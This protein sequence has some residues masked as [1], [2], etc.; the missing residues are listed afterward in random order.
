MKSFN[1]E[2]FVTDLSNNLDRFDFSAPFPDIHDIS[3]AFDNLIE[4][5]KTTIMLILF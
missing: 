3:A 4:I 5:I 1:S 2:T